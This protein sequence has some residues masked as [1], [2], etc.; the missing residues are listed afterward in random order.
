MGP[1]EMATVESR[2]GTSPA[3]ASTVG[4]KLIEAFLAGRS[5]H[6]RRAYGEDLDVF[7]SHLGLETR[8]EAMRYLIRLPAGEA[9]GVLLAYRAALLERRLAPH[10]INRRLTG[11]RSAVK[12][13]RTLGWTHWTPDIGGVKAE[14]FRDTAGPGLQG[15]T[16]LIEVSRTQHRA[17][18]ARDEALLSLMFDMGLRRG[19]VVSL[20]LEDVLTDS[21]RLMVKGKGKAQRAPLTVPEPTMESLQAWLAVRVQVASLGEQALCVGFAGRRA[22]ERITGRGLHHLV[23]DLGKRVGIR[24]RPHGLRHAAVTEVLEATNG[25]IDS[26]QKFARHASPATTMRYNDN[27]KDAAGEAARLVASRRLTRR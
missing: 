26:A 16:R 6:T 1:E 2:L 17:K 9:N 27:R 13:A 7:A 18:A 14:S 25:N 15:V 8:A 20:D 24:T 23:H 22:G 10:T 4:E 3:I 5:E 21:R 12:L 19:E 11:I